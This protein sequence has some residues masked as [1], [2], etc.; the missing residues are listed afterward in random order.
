MSKYIH[1]DKPWQEWL[2]Y[3]GTFK[4]KGRRGIAGLF[5]TK[6]KCKTNRFQSLQYCRL[7]HRT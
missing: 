6:D 1:E 4:S 5:V 3:K 7:F 2:E